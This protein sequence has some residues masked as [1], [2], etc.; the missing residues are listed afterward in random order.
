[1]SSIT[2]LLGNFSFQ[3]DLLEDSYRLSSRIRAVICKATLA[4]S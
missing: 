2:T 1:M 3:I 4:S